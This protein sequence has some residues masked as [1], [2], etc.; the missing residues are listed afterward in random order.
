MAGSLE[1]L[2]PEKVHLI[3]TGFARGSKLELSLS[4]SDIPRMDVMSKSDPFCIAYIRAGEDCWEKLGKTETIYD[5]HECKWA[6]KFYI[7]KLCMVGSAMR[8][9]VYDR[10]SERDVV[11]DHDFIGY[12][13]G[14][15]VLQMFDDEVSHNKME[16]GRHGKDG[17]LGFLY[18]TLDWIERPL[19]NYNVTFQ[20]ELEYSMRAKM[21]YQVMRKTFSDSQYIVVFRS[22]LL[23]KDQTQFASATLRLSQLSA[24]CSSRMFRIELFQFHPMGRSKVMGYFKTTVDELTNRTQSSAQMEWNPCSDALSTA[25]VYAST[26]HDSPKSGKT[27]KISIIEGA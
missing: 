17:K 14:K 22:K 23:D 8:F 13:E 10:D 9:E 3:E 6:R 5:T 27:F 2:S 25:V 21:F 20:V 11:K 12:T 7:S 18:L 26:Q 24:G 4:C 1:E 16:I 15:P 19:I